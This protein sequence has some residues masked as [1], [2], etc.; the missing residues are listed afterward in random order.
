MLDAGAV[1]AGASDWPVST[2][3]VFK[4]I[5]QAETR[6]GE[7]RGGEK[8][9]LDAGQDMP[10][11]AMLY[12]YTINAARAMKQEASIGSIEP[13]KAADFALV[14]RDVLTVPAEQMRDTQVLST[15]VAGEWVYRA[16]E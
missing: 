4:G 10:R 5:Y 9:V 8:G 16:K 6:S 12:A 14:D 2:P 13:G 3:E 15:M 1:I 11:E 7:T